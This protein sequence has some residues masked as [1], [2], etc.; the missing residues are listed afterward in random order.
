MYTKIDTLPRELG[1][2]AIAHQPGDFGPPEAG[3]DVSVRIA[4]NVTIHVLV[5]KLENGTVFG[6]VRAFDPPLLSEHGEIK[7]EDKVCFPENTVT[8]LIRAD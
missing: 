6:A 2:M 1:R 7:R 5:E 8:C 4:E 3:D